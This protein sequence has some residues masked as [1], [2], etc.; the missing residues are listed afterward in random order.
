MTLFIFPRHLFNKRAVDSEFTFEALYVE[1][2]GKHTV[3]LLDPFALSE[4]FTHKVIQ[5]LAVH[6]GARD[7][8]YRGWMLTVEEYALLEQALLDSDITLKTSSEQYVRAHHLPGW[9]EVFEDLTPKSYFWNPFGGESLEEFCSSL[10]EQAYVVKDYV[11]SR[12]HDW[13]T[14]CFAP[15]VEA[16]PAVINEF[17]RLQTEDGSFVGEVVVREFESFNKEAGEA[18]VWWV[19]GEFV[20]SLP[21]PDNPDLLPAVD[22][23]FLNTV[24]ASVKKLGCPFVVTD[25]ASTVDG[26]WRIIEVG[27]GQVSGLPHGF[28]GYSLWNAL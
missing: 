18:R 21:H 4:G 20:A 16:L 12:K 23:G 1:R 24:Q 3:A 11:K 25:I 26:D 13:D 22:K 27:D 17:V 7:V 14:A 6:A 9:Y 10:P 2:S 28:T 19:D 5:S 8:V 15:S